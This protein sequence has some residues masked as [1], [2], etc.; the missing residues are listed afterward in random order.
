M[1]RIAR[2]LRADAVG[3]PGDQRDL[4]PADEVRPGD[5]IQHRPELMLH[6]GPAVGIVIQLTPVGGR[7]A[8]TASAALSRAPMTSID[9]CRIGLDVRWGCAFNPADSLR[10]LA[11]SPVRLRRLVVRGAARRHWHDTLH[12]RDDARAS[13]ARRIAARFRRTGGTGATHCRAVATHL[14]RGRDTLRHGGDARGSWSRRI[15]ARGRRTWV[16]VATRC[17]TGTAHVRHGRDALR[18][19]DGARASR[20]R[21]AATRARRVAA[22]GRRTGGTGATHCRAVPTHPRRGHDALRH[23]DGARASRSRRVATLGRRT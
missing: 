12:H 2:Q 5:A 16:M 8:E 7:L 18:H 23:G 21:R 6:R 17:G 4:L 14:R 10:A 3:P 19:G 20:S 9:A 13:R 1:G 11:D 15:A 22:R